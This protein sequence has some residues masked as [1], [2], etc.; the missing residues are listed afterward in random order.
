[1]TAVTTEFNVGTGGSKILDDAL[2]TVD[3]AAA[4]TGA[5]A[6]LA[7]VGFGAQ[8]DYKS[9]TSAEPLP[10]FAN[11]GTI[12]GAA[13]AAAQTTANASLSSIDGKVPAL[14]TGRVP[15]DG[16]AVTQ[17]VSAASLPLPAG[18]ATAAKQP[19]IGTA[20]TASADVLTVQGRA[21]MTALL[22]DGSGATQPVS[23]ASLPLPTGAATAANQ[24]TSNASLSSIDGKVPALV[25]GRTPVDG[26]GVTQPVSAASL[27]LPAGAATSALQ[28]T[29]NTSLGDISTKLGS[30]ATSRA[31]GAVDANTQRTISASDDPGVTSLAAIN[32]KMGTLGRQAAA[33]SASH[34]LSTEDLAALQFAKSTGAVNSDTTRIVPA[35]DATFAIASD[36]RRAAVTITRPANVTAYTAGDNIGGAIT[37]PTIGPSAGHVL[38]TSADLR[39]DVTAIPSGLTTTRLHLYTGTPP[40]ALADN[41]AWDLPSG[42]RA[43]YI[44]YIDFSVFL[45]LGSTLFTQVD[46]INKQIQ[47]AA[48]SSSLFGYLVT[49]GAF[50]PA[51][52]S[53]VLQITLR[54]VAV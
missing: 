47:L 45:D 17:P 20:G 25:S 35:S 51:A 28:T 2:T 44:G 6:Q 49:T 46:G 18:A 15:V 34:V 29:G 31:A 36:G 7:K 39:Y 40:S 14:V 24:S 23:A 32:A 26:S 48:A 50:T 10:V 52:N 38:I 27:P 8:G 19:A 11:L 37:F 12:G 3:G 9:V 1:M 53:E 4:P 16:S 22:V 30:A 41:A 54:T 5:R 43:S 42:D 13:T 21:G 33:S